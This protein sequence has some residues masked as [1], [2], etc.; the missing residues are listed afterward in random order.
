MRVERSG[1]CR[2]ERHRE[3]ARLAGEE[4]RQAGVYRAERIRIRALETEV[5][6]VERCVADVGDRQILRTIRSH[7]DT[8]K[9]QGPG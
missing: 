1:C 3:C 5:G 9:I 2:S 8:A 4:I 7:C 6:N